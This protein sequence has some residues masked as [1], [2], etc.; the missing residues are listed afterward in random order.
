[1][2][3]VRLTGIHDA[4]VNVI[5]HGT[6]SAAV[7]LDR[8]ACTLD[9]PSQ[10]QQAESVPVELRHTA[11]EIIAD[12]FAN[13]RI[14]GTEQRS[15]RRHADLLN[16]TLDLQRDAQRQSVPNVHFDWGA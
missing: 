16:C 6:G 10:P 9:I 5:V 7:E 14:L 11:Y 1:G 4:A 2:Q 8:S 15:F 13:L 12:D 3:A